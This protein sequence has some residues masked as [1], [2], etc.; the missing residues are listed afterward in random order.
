MKTSTKYTIKLN[1]E[2]M[3][4]LRDL[5]RIGM[6]SKYYQ[7]FVSKECDDIDEEDHQMNATLAVTQFVNLCPSSP[8]ESLMDKYIFEGVE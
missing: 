7:D 6:R 2:E 8:I 3:S 1:N 5:V 4:M